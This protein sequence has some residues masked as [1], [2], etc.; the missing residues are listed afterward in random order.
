MDSTAGPK[1]TP[2]NLSDVRT[3]SALERPTKVRR[4][5]FLAPTSVDPSLLEFLDSLPDILKA[6][7]LRAVV[8]AIVRAFQIGKPVVLGIGGH[9]IKCG[10]AP[11]I[12][13]LLERKIIA[14][15]AMN[16][17]AS[18]HEFEVA[19]LR[20]TSEDVADRLETGK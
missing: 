7:D 13:S 4:E 17:G 3:Y 14:A 8:D 10:L 16:G 5:S 20:T 12:I 11:L 2:A 18:I 9:V 1:H 6:A 19:T 15:V